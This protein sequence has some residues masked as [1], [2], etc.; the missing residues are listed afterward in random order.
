MIILITK[1][2]VKQINNYSQGSGNSF[3]VDDMRA[4]FSW[5]AIKG[6]ISS[7][8]KAIKLYALMLSGLC[9]SFVFSL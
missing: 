3:E 6:K 1:T 8:H 9:L 2:I 7:K 4:A 5:R